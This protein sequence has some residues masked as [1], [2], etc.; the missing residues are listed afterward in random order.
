M[1]LARGAAGGGGGLMSDDRSG[2]GG[3]RLDFSS[4]GQASAGE[5]SSEK[6]R[7]P[8]GRMV[9]IRNV[10]ADNLEAEMAIIRELVEDYPYVAMDTEFPGVVA[11]PVGDFNQPDYQYQTLRCNVDMLKMIQLGLS[12]ANEKGELPES[13]CC[14][15]QF[16]FAFNLSEDMYA[17]D[18][19]QLLKNSG[20]DFQGHQ[21]RGID[22]QDFG[23][24]LMTSG[25]V[26][27]PNVTWLSFH[28]GYDF[29]YL[30][31]L[32]TSTPLPAQESEF[33]ELLQLYFPKLYDIKY[34]VSSQDGFHG[35][36]NKLADD[37]KVERIGPMH[38]AGSDSLLTEQVFL[39]VADVYFNGVANLDRG[40]SEGKFS[41]QLY[42]Y[43][44][45][46]TGVY[47][48]GNKQH[49]NGGGAAGTLAT[50]TAAA[51]AAAAAAA[52]TAADAATDST[53]DAS[54]NSSGTTTAAAASSAAA[55]TAGT[56][57][58]SA[59]ASAV[60]AASTATATAAAATNVVNSTAAAAA[61]ANPPISGDPNPAEDDSAT[62][63]PSGEGGDAGE[64]KGGGAGSS[65][66]A[67]S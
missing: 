45:N 50:A 25:L 31:K 47:R 28:S 44:G 9:E 23:E 65:S 46:Q 34:L 20:I 55:A 38:Q 59:V 27:L 30:I 58:A 49:N 2:G 36:L 33:F 53:T 12:F 42:G 21:R 52:T 15:W 13:G 5:Q 10:W 14:T 43:G 18:S 51:A 1:D 26:L 8:D 35:G 67:G 60:V 11:R 22:L 39:K 61:M 66:P 54:N 56:A 41:G 24:L 3:G 17:H 29:G 6:Y 62:G 40:K 16:N 32:L 64:G 48:P 57:T 19:I 7:A 63:A 37:L 4:N